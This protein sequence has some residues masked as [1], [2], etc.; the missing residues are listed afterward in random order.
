MRGIRMY[1]LPSL[2]G[3]GKFLR[4]IRV[5]SLSLRG[6]EGAACSVVRTFLRED[7]AEIISGLHFFMGSVETERLPGL[8]EGGGNRMH[9]TYVRFGP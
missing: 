1:R 2:S 9:K 7:K 6:C 5:V 8:G 3:S 4:G